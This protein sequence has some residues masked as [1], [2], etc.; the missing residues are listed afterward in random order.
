MVE[1]Y[2]A[3]RDQVVN[4]TPMG[5]DGGGVYLSPRLEAWAAVAEL[6]DVPR[7]R[8]GPLIESA[9][10]L[11]ECVEDRE[12]FGLGVQAGRLRAAARSVGGLPCS[13]RL[14]DSRS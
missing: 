8:R 5:M 1:F 11:H 6:L 13:G 12:R 9:R 4:Q 2:S 10:Y 14:R 3:V 7:G